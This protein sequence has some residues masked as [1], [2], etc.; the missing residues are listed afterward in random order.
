MS[1]LSWR[2]HMEARMSNDF[3]F[4][5]WDRGENRCSTIQI[6]I[7]LFAPPETSLQ[8][9]SPA[10]R[11]V[12]MVIGPPKKF[13]SLSA[14]CAILHLL[15]RVPSL[16][17]MDRLYGT[18]WV[19]SRSKKSGALN[20]SWA[21]IQHVS[22]VHPSQ[23]SH[24]T[25]QIIS[26]T[27]EVCC[28]KALDWLTCPPPICLIITACLK[29][30]YTTSELLH[31]SSP[32]PNCW[33]WILQMHRSFWILYRPVFLVYWGIYIIVKNKLLVCNQDQ[34]GGH[35][36]NFTLDSKTRSWSRNCLTLCIYSSTL[37]LKMTCEIL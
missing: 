22:C 32:C 34:G 27:S 4:I 16:A 1:K 28:R 36:T 7:C 9:Q 14:I 11:L 6:F 25:S 35:P 31:T 37:L 19:I 13:S 21:K 30:F 23:T 2:R 5:Y 18:D 24:W 12:A 8:K 20:T 15:V 29:G 17:S 10:A 33:S 3:W 26:S